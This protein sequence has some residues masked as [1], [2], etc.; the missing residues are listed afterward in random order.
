MTKNQLKNIIRE[1]INESLINEGLPSGQS[2]LAREMS[3]K[4]TM[5]VH[6]I[7]RPDLNR[8]A[9]H[10]AAD[11]IRLIDRDQTGNSPILQGNES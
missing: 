1:C 4:L 8:K 6:K 3:W 10:H 2:E 11:I 7:K 5:I 9:G